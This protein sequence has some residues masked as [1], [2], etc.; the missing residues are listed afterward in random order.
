MAVGALLASALLQKITAEAACTCSYTPALDTIFANYDV[1]I[2]YGGEILGENDITSSASTAGCSND[3]TRW[4]L[5]SMTTYPERNNQ[6]VQFKST[7]DAL[8]YKRWGFKLKFDG[9]NSGFISPG[10]T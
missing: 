7:K 3:D 1:E 9:S 10:H 6:V 5:Y 8:V 2:P 4:D